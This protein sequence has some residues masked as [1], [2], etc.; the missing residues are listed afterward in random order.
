[1]KLQQSPSM[2]TKEIS[3]EKIK[4]RVQRETKKLIKNALKRKEELHNK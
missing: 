4:K 2:D 3:P 1:M